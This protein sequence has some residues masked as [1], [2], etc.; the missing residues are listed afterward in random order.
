MQPL[1]SAIAAARQPAQPSAIGPAVIVA[2]AL[3]LI[4]RFAVFRDGKGTAAS[5]ALAV[6][7]A[8]TAGWVLLAVA[9]P[10]AAMQA[11]SGTASGFATLL[12]AAAR[13]LGGG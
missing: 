8:L 5:R 13:I 1:P 6:L 3:V 9:Q 7:I 4:W 12:A 10:T 11:A 2:I